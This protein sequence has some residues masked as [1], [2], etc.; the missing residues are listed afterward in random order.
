M[1]KRL[2]L[3]LILFIFLFSCQSENDTDSIKNNLQPEVNENYDKAIT[4]LDKGQ[5]DSAQVYFD[6]AAPEFLSA[7]DSL[8]AATC[9]I[10]MA[11]TLYIEGDYYAGQ[12]MSLT[13]DNLLD[14]SKTEHQSLMAY[15][16]NNLGNC[17]SA[18]GGKLSAIEYY[19]LAERFAESEEDKNYYANNAAVTLYTAGKYE[20]ALAL[21]KK[22]LEA[23]GASKKEKA[24]SLSNYANTRWR[25]DSSYN[26][27]KDLYRALQMRI[28]LG[29]RYGLNSSYAHLFD[30]H[31][32]AGNIDSA[33][34]YA[35]KSFDLASKINVSA[36][37]IQALGKLLNVSIN[38]EAKEYFKSY[39]LLEDSVRNAR[40]RASNQY[41]LIRYQ[42]DKIKINN[43]RL[44]TQVLQANFKRSRDRVI[45]AAVF[46]VALATL[47]Y[48][49]QQMRR[50]KEKI[51]AEG[52]KKV[53]QIRLA[54]SKKVHDVVANGIYRVMS[55][56]EYSEQ[57]DKEELLDKLEVMYEKSRNISYEGEAIEGLAEQGQQQDFSMQISS[58][59]SSFSSASVRVLIVGN[60]ENLWADFSRAD[61]NELL[62]IFQELMVNMKKHSRATEVI[63][64]FEKNDQHLKI[65]YSDNGVGISSIEKNRG[66]GLKNTE[67]RIERLSGRINFVSKEFEG[68]SVEIL[69][70]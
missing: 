35:Q 59:L 67:T 62:I 38:E 56:L 50:R 41:A 45:M 66:N 13:A 57:V 69:L 18:Y 48:Y 63:W 22:N 6:L 68:F 49:V 15:N 42:T 28:E 65:L 25:V 4:F 47:G 9:Y 23:P 16:Y 58:L 37:K 29:D 10:Q 12:E 1:L 17:I 44:Q 54:T 39:K 5:N 51:K 26:P 33:R 61:Q 46:A 30:Y 31:Y 3:L 40:L 19:K 34:I 36:D 52:E 21:H 8:Q 14:S 53:Q 27:L 32:K 24:R 55:E 70:L 11:I 60:Q 7:G 64:R 2:L 20:Q 43:L